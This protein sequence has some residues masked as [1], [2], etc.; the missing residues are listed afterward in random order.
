[1]MLVIR[2]RV[3]DWVMHKLHYRLF[4]TKNNYLTN[5]LAN[6]TPNKWQRKRRNVLQTQQANRQQQISVQSF[7]RCFL[8]TIPWKCE[9]VF[10][11]NLQTKISSNTNIKLSLKTSSSFF[12]FSWN[13]SL[14]LSTRSAATFSSLWWSFWVQK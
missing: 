10:K 14:L 1:M 11:I 3:H 5:K 7:C 4:W 8:R 6:K 9:G 12:S 13:F 2:F